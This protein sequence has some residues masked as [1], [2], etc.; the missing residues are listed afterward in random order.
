[1]CVPGT[2]V[3]CDASGEIVDGDGNVVATADGELL[4]RAERRAC[5]V[6]CLC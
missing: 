1:M 3:T 2:A 6:V 5:G 4:V